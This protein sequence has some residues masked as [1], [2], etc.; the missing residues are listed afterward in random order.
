MEEFHHLPDTYLLLWPELGFLNI[1]DTKF[2]QSLSKLNEH[3][4]KNDSELTLYEK[5]WH[6]N[7]LISTDNKTAR[8]KFGQIIE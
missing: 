4:V 6:I 7:I 8:V 1:H 5:L 2:K 3:L